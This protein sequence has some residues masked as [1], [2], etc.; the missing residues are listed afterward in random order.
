MKQHNQTHTMYIQKSLVNMT[1]V[2]VLHCTDVNV[3]CC[4]CRAWRTV[5]TQSTPDCT[6]QRPSDSKGRPCNKSERTM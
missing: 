5:R 1:S 6:Q 4:V 3:V 2:G